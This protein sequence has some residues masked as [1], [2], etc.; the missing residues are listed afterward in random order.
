MSQLVFVYHTATPQ[1]ANAGGRSAGVPAVSAPPP[2]REP[3]SR[4]PNLHQPRQARLLVRKQVFSTVV[5]GIKLESM[6]IVIQLCLTHITTNWGKITAGQSRTIVKSYCV[7]RL[8]VDG[9]YVLIFYYYW[10][11]KVWDVNVTLTF[12]TPTNFTLEYRSLI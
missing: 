5:R 2:A 10:R 12:L 3:A 7:C 9:L 4:T 8:V 6:D 11:H 1:R